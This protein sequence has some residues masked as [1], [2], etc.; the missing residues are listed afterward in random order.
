VAPTVGLASP[1]WGGNYF[2]DHIVLGDQARQW[3]HPDS[4]RVMTYREHDPTL[5]SRLSDHCPVS[6]GLDMP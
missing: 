2:I 3:L 4:L 6:I 5:Q 1:C